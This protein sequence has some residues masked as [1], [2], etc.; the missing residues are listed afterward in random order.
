MIAATTLVIDDEPMVR[1]LVRRI[2]EP[3]VC[4]VVDVGDGETGL[5][6]IQRRRGSIDVVLTDLSMPG[7]DGV[8][9]VDV[10]TEHHPDLPVAC[11][12][13]YVD[14]YNVEC[15]LSVPLLSKPFS[16]DGLRGLIV[17][18]IER[19]RQF[20]AGAHEQRERAGAAGTENE[21]LGARTQMGVARAVDLIAI[22]RALHSSRAN[23]A[24]QD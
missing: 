11:M 10:L 24:R 17:P 13:A 1:K 7:I 4:G 15:R 8:D 21:A 14:Q 16:T 5:E 19:S 3:E 20:R 22:A 23:R 9:L 2:L 6:L 18:L 12:S